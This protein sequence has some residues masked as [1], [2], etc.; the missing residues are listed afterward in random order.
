MYFMH[1][2]VEILKTKKVNKTD[3]NIEIDQTASGIVFLS[4]LLKRQKNG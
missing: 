3:V 1:L 2:H 4:L